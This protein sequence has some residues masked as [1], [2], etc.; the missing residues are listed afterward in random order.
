MSENGY[1]AAP[2][3]KFPKDMVIT[4]ISMNNNSPMN[5]SVTLY[6]DEKPAKLPSLKKATEG[7]RKATKAVEKAKKALE[8]A[9]LAYNEAELA[10]ESAVG[11]QMSARNVLLQVAGK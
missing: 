7:Y 11:D 2:T 4:G 6:R 3:I 9:R 10:A 1:A 5:M 8:A